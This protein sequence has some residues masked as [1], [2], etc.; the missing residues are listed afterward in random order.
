MRVP[1]TV[2]AD[3]DERTRTTL[4]RLGRQNIFTT[5]AHHPDLLHRWLVFGRHVLAG[6]TL[7]ARERELVIL[8]T[9]WRCG[10]EYEFAQHRKLGEEAGLTRPEIDKVASE[11]TDWPERDLVLL[12]ATDQLVAT[13][14]VDDSLWAAL[15]RDWTLQQVLDIVFAVG[16][17]TLVSTALNT[18]QV[19][20]DE[21][22]EGFPS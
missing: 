15:G 20:L 18:F 14:T 3:W 12:R 8:R 11:A 17:Y 10:S 16:Q 19:A 2:E 9:G 13:H 1:L 5:L 21:G 6:S 4:D 7:P 22:L